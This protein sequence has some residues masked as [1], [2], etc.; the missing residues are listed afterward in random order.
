MSCLWQVTW[1]QRCSDLV[2]AVQCPSV[3]QSQGSDPSLLPVPGLLPAW[4]KWYLCALAGLPATDWVTG[5]LLPRIN[6]PVWSVK[7][8]GAIT[9]NQ[10]FDIYCWLSSGHRGLGCSCTLEPVAKYFFYAFR[11]NIETIPGT[12]TGTWHGRKTVSVLSARTVGP[13]PLSLSLSHYES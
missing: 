4:W 13:S 11:L 6:V 10:I 3:S 8:G 5:L 1:R 2:M 9:T 12:E 7:Y